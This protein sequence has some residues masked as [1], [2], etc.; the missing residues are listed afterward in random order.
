MN[1][2]ELYDKILKAS[3]EI[4]KKSIE[5]SNYIIVS[6]K[7]YEIIENLDI[8]KHRKKKLMKINN[9]NKKTSE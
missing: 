3:E 2:K 1:N 7:I 5:S 8:K 4:S 6:P 9:I